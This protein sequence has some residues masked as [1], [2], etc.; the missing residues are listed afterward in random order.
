MFSDAS[1]VTFGAFSASLD[2]T[3]VSGMWEPEDIG[4]ISTFRKLK[5]IYFVLLSY[6]AQ[7]N[8]R[9]LKSLLTIRAPPELLLSQAP[10]LISRLWLWTFLISVLLTTLF[11]KRNGSQGHLINGQI[12]S[13]DLLTK[14]TGP[15]ILLYFELLTPNGAL[16]QLISLHRI[17]TPRF[18][19]S[20][21]N[22]QRC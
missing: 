12:F 10:K 2:S 16:T 7:L 15:L 22:L 14:M 11:W 13:A 20:T 6:V 19:G 5:A 1:D 9:E 3:V 21:L 17:E 8:T 4:R 18:Q